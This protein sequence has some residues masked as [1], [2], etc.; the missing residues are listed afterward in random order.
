MA[1]EHTLVLD[2]TNFDAEVLQSKVPV[3]VDFWA[4]WCAPCKMIAP[5]LDEVAKDQ[6]NNAKVAKVNVQEHQELAARYGVQYLPTLLFFKNGE[7]VDKHVGAGVTK[8]NLVE[9]LKGLL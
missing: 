9:K 5:V 4:D 2:S 8:K 7:I 1:S 3:L 6:V